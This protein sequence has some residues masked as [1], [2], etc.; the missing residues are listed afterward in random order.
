MELD[1]EAT[2]PACERAYGF[3]MR[4]GETVLAAGYEARWH[5]APPV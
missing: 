5:A 4:R 1:P 2:R 3:L